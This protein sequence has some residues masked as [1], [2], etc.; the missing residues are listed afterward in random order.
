[1]KS[2]KTF[3]NLTPSTKPWNAVYKISSNKAKRSQI[4]TTLQKP[5]GTLTT[6][7]NEKVTYMLEYLIT[8]RRRRQLFRL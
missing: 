4:L 7:I 2:W 5:D 1:M 6:D 3:C 8:K